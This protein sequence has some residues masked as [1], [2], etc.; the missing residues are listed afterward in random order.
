MLAGYVEYWGAA[1]LLRMVSDP[2]PRP[3]ESLV[4]ITA[5]AVNHLDL[6][7]ASG[8]FHFR[9]PLPY[10]PGTDGA[11]VVVASDRLPPG[12]AVQIRG[13]GVGLVRDGTWAELA[14][15]PNAALRLIPSELDPILVATYHVPAITA[16]AAVHEVGGLRPGER[17]AVTGAAG[18]IGS[19][20]VQLAIEG[21]AAEVFALVSRAD[22][23]SLAPPEATVVVRDDGLAP[24]KQGGGVD[25]LIDTVGGPGLS[26]LLSA[27]KPGGRAAL[28][29]YTAGTELKLELP[30][31]LAQDV[32]LLPVNL[33][34][35]G[36]AMTA[37]AGK[38]LERLARHDLKLRVETYT[39]SELAHA[40]QKLSSG[41][42][43]GRVAVL[44]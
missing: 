33:S 29:G 12:A 34:R 17:V 19:L 23:K 18:A 9:P 15:V 43:S 42:A 35:R 3:G 6:T 21:G 25:L 40:V 41:R 31:W 1:P 2:V 27:V 30:N 5:A 11:G 36:T 4:R 24:L 22:K 8:R 13:H 16:H 20:A 10:V 38:L 28:V 37:V 7:V 14:S 32:S 44:P 26:A 39:L